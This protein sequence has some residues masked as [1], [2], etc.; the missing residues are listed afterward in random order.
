MVLDI[1]AFIHI[2][3]YLDRRSTAHV[4]ELKPALDLVRRTMRYW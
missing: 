1:A 4:I 3:V 2:D